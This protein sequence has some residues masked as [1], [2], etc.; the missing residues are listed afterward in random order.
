MKTEQTSS[1]RSDTDVEVV[2]S[3]S[4]TG[5][6]APA[7]QWDI[8]P[9][10]S[11]TK[12]E[13]GMVTNDDGSFHINSSVTVRMP[14]KWDGQVFCLLESEMGKQIRQEIHITD[15]SEEGENDKVDEGGKYVVDGYLHP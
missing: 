14:V 8:S 5:K 11:S 1:R 4:A 15:N 12:P 7:I 3:C 9:G 2:L 13:Q 6:P 10:V